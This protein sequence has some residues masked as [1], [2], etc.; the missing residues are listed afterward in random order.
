MIE[1][2]NNHLHVI[3]NL[4]INHMKVQNVINKRLPSIFKKVN[5]Q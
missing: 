5:S 4:I 3:L 2:K 1:K